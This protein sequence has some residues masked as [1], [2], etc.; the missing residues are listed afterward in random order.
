MSDELAYYENL[1]KI[2]YKT[3]G[4]RFGAAG[5]LRVKERLSVG[6]IAFLAVYVLS[7]LIISLSYPEIFTVSH[8]RFFNAVSAI[9]SV[10]VLVLSLMDFALGRGVQAEK[11]H[12]SALFISRLM[13]DL[14]RQLASPEPDV[15]KMRGI[16]TDYER[17]IAE[18][19]IS[20][21]ASD[22]VRWAYGEARSATTLVQ[23]LFWIR[24]QV[25][26]LWFYASSM[27]IYIILVLS[28]V[29][30]TSWYAIY[31]IWPRMPSG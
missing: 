1:T 5:A 30:A 9:A 20:H 19:Q 8:A 16:A 4:C 22:L 13:R 27:F 17:Q 26:D 31:M 29:L 14:E 15:E 24:K 25:F 2:M 10:S 23:L 3:R 12:Q 7:W 18:T 6:T 28:I 11:L 21:S